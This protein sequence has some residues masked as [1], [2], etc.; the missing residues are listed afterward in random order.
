[1]VFWQPPTAQE[2]LAKT[3]G[4]ALV[5]RD[6]IAVNDVVAPI[7]KV[8]K[9]QAECNIFLRRWRKVADTCV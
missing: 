6:V 5:T 9:L 8:Q 3:K 2:P 1:M 4:H 7:S